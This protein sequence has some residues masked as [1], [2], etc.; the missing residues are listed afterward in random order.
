VAL[1]IVIALFA[2]VIIGLMAAS[3]ILP[4]MAMRAPEIAAQ[5]EKV[6]TETAALASARSMLSRTAKRL[7]AISA[8]VILLEATAKKLE[9]K[10]KSIDPLQPILAV[11]VF[12]ASKKGRGARAT[13]PYIGIVVPP[14]PRRDTRLVFCWAQTGAEARTTISTIYRYRE[15]WGLEFLKA[16]PGASKG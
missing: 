7:E 12:T 9:D 11:E 4:R 3:M 15:G 5:I 6:Q 10:A 8:E 2:I 14:E 16:N 1:T 13:P